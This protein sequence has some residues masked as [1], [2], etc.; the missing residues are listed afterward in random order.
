MQVK[1]IVPNIAANGTEEG[2]RFYRGALG[3]EVVMDMEWIVTLATG[4]RSPV[5]VS[6]VTAGGS[7]TPVPDLSIEVDDI[8]EAYSRMESAGFDIEY[9]LTDEPWGV[10]RFFTRD[11]YGKLVNVMSHL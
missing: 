7:D 4:A 2:L 9:P 11:P 5:Q 8:E 10:R 3:L 6:I 1:R